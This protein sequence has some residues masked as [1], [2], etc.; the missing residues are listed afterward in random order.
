MRH[1]VHSHTFSRR[2]NARK[3]LVKGLVI[4]MVEH[5]RIRTTLA[6]A[7]EL[8]RHVERAIT[9]GRKGDVGT[10]RLLESRFGC[11]KTAAKIVTDLSP[12]F[13]ARAGGYTRI[14]KLVPRSGDNAPMALLEFVDYKLPTEKT[15]GGE[16]TVKGD[17]GA[18]A[19]AKAI[20]KKRAAKRKSVR[21]MK[22]RSRQANRK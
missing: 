14:L 16:T 9:L 13:K 12:R 7:K 22:A 15:K 6:K 19:K 5:E 21:S 11:D 17:A 10:R 4:S 8:R 2:G 3:A 1:K 20:S 18:K